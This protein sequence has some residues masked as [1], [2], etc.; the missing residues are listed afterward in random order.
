MTKVYLIQK[1]ALVILI[2]GTTLAFNPF[3]NTDVFEFPKVLALLISVGFLTLLNIFDIYSNSF[4]KI[5]IKKILPE[6]ICI[7]LLFVSQILAFIFSTDAET[8]LMGAAG[9]Y[10]G[11][12]TNM[13]YIL[14]LLNS[15]YFFIKNKSGDRV[16]NYLAII[17]FVA[18]ALAISPYVFPLTFPF[19]FFTPSFFFNRVYGTFGNPNYL[20]VFVISAL[21]FLVFLKNVKK[22]FLYPAVM[23][24]LV[25][26][27]LTGSRSAW[28]ACA[29]AFLIG[30]AFMAI[31]LKK[32]RVL[33][34]TLV[35]FA[36]LFTGVAMKNQL[37][38]IIPQTQRLSLD[39]ENSTSIKTRLYLWKAGFEMSLKRPI[40]GYGQDMIQENIEPYLPEYLKANDAFF[41]DRSHSEFVDVLI[42]S[43]F[44]G[45]AGYLTLILLILCRSFKK[46]IKN[47]AILPLTCF[48]AFISLV[49]FHTLNFS[50]TS[51][52]V[53]LYLF[54]G[55]LVDFYVR[56]HNNVPA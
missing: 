23:M 41:V 24:V 19:Y 37:L 56:D 16:F 49:M 51:S 2:I 47:P 17:L 30:G 6:L 8:S 48:I 11:F 29:L 34:A 28:V 44:I 13:H 1:W 32:Y 20:A 54:M 36:L 10:Q 15:F 52:N 7:L 38:P 12:L 27:F 39:S 9:R 5:S 53:L 40:Q 3:I 31:R 21:P 45:L 26:L 18:C 55:Y 50:T 46:L 22:I 33:M 42:T 25:T 14:L 35:V 43:G 4:P